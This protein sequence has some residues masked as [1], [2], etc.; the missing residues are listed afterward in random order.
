MNIQRSS[1]LGCWMD[2]KISHQTS[3][4]II[5]FPPWV[6]FL[7][8]EMTERT[9]RSVVVR[10]GYVNPNYQKSIPDILV[11]GFQEICDLTA[12]NMVSARYGYIEL[13]VLLPTNRTI[14]TFQFNQC[15]TMGR[16]CSIPFQTV[17]SQRWI[18]YLRRWSTCRRL[19]SCIR[20][21][22]SRPC[23][24]VCLIIEYV[25]YISRISLEI[26]RLTLSKQEWVANSAIKDA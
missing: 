12:A 4:E 11:I 19:F 2:L 8:I 25:A 7:R 3:E 22:R 20:S 9:V 16:Q 5:V 24:Q 26:F 23:S 14:V 13:V 6:C 1:M 10:L 18:H 17:L 21:S 15:A